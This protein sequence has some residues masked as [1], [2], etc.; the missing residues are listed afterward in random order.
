MQKLTILVVFAALLDG[1]ALAKPPAGAAAHDDPDVAAAK[2][3][4]QRGVAHYN[5]TEYREAISEF[6]DAYRLHPDPVFLYNLGQSY[7]LSDQPELALQFYKTSP[8]IITSPS[9]ARAARLRRRS[10]ADT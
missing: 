10:A 9:S 6:Q 1:T 3:H 2:K 4:F 5:L 7:R 8:A